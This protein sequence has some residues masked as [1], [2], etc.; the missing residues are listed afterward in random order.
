MLITFNLQEVKGIV[1][2]DARRRKLRGWN[3][4]RWPRKGI[5]VRREEMG[6][7]WRKLDQRF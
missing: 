1:L 4:L 5:V 6:W 3:S 2:P 7:K